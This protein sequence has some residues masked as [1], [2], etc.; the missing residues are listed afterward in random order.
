MGLASVPAVANEQGP[1]DEGCQVHGW[2]QI[3]SSSPQGGSITGRLGMRRGQ[4][5]EKSALFGNEGGSET[6]P[7]WEIGE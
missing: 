2:V 6:P 3:P 4:R 1:R 5:K 7:P